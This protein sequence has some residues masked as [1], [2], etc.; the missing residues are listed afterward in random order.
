[1]S[2]SIL[3]G[4]VALVG[5]VIPFLT[6]PAAAETRSNL[7]EPTENGGGKG[8]DCGEPDEC[9][10]AKK[11]I[12]ACQTVCPPIGYDGPNPD[13]PGKAGKCH[14]HIPRGSGPA[15]TPDGE[16]HDSH[17]A[18]EDCRRYNAIPGRCLTCLQGSCT[19]W[20]WPSC[21]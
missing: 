14:M 10:A 13:Q 20:S 18:E 16:F 5:G 15:L 8:A 19:G 1:M 7:D 12:R 4:F 21:P 6:T 9:K 11:C 2:R 3:F 17:G